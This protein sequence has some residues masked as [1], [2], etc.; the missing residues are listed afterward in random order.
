MNMMANAGPYGGPY[1][2]TAGQ[3]MPGAGLGPQLQNKAGLPSNMAAQF[4][5]EKKTPAGQGMSGMVGFVG[6]SSV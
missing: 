3:G 6:F 1:G 2:Q 5:M 4:S